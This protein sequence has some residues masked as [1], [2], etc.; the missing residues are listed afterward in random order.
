MG[1]GK[2]DEGVAESENRSERVDEEEVDET[3]K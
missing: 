2:L 3:R 1:S